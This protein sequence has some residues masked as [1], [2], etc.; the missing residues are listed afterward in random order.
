MLKMLSCLDFF[1]K[2]VPHLIYSY[3]EEKSRLRCLWTAEPVTI[4]D[5]IIESIS[6]RF[7][8]RGMLW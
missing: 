2:I 7:Q 1:R 5:S 8:I 4:H 3:I 6:Y